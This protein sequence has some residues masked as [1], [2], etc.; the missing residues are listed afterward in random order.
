M[1]AERWKRVDELLQAALRVPAE[2]QEK[3]LREQ[4]G[5]NAELL[6]E[7]RSLL[8]S[9]RRAGSFLEPPAIDLRGF[10]FIRCQACGTKNAEPAQRCQ[11]C[12]ATLDTSLTMSISSEVASDG[13]GSASR[14]RPS[15]G[16]G[17]APG[18]MVAAR[19][20][21]VSLLGRGGMGEVYGAD[22]LK[23]GQRVALKF[24]PA[25]RLNS[26]SWRDQFY[27]EVRM[28]R[29]VSHPNV[30]RV[31]DV[32]ESDGHLF[33]SMEFV[34]GEDLASLLRRIGRLP[35]DKA[36]EIA[37]QL[38][39]GL[40]AAHRSGVLHRDLK[41]SNVMIDGKGHARITDFGL[42]VATSNAEKE[43]SP[44]GTP[45]YLA[46][47]L[48]DGHPPSVQSDLYALGLVLYELFTGKRAFEAS[49][50]AEFHRKQS[51]TNPTPP[52]NVVKNLDPAVERTILRCLDRD[53]EQRPRSALSV[54]AALPGGDPLAAALA[55]GETPSPEMVAAAGPEGSLRPAT[56]WICFLSA[57]VLMIVTL[58]FLSPRLMSWGR[59]PMNKSPEVLTDRAQE[60]SEKLG[61]SGALDWASWLETEY[62]YLDYVADDPAGKKVVSAAVARPWPAP[63]SFWYRQSPEWMT[64][65]QR[66]EYSDV[67]QSQPPYE[68]VGMV[69]LNL[70]V[71]GK[72]LFLRAVPPQVGTGNAPEPD[73]GLLFDAAGLDKSQ[74]HPAE[75]KWLPPEA[76]DSR[77]DW[78]GHIAGQPDL[79]LHVAAAAYRGVPVYFQMIAPWD[80]PLRNPSPGLVGVKAKLA[81]SL[82]VLIFS[83][84][85]LVGGFFAIRNIRRGRGDSKGGLRF[86]S[87]TAVL[88]GVGVVSNEHFVPDPGYNIVQ[89][90]FLGM[91]LFVAVVCWIGYMAVEP[92]ARRVW[93]NVLVSWQRLLNG[94]IRDPLMGRHLLLGI[95]VGAAVQAVRGC[96]VVLSHSLRMT[97]V[98]YEFCRGLFSSIGNGLYFL[99][100]YWMTALV[101]LAVLSF[102]TRFVRLRWLATV[103][104]GVLMIVI[105]APNDVVGLWRLGLFYGVG[106]VVLT[107]IGFIGVIG[108]FLTDILTEAPPLDFSKWYAGR[109]IAALVVPLALL[110]YGFYVSL[111]GQPMF[112]RASKED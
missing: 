95:L 50:A 78:E 16:L 51:E 20:R 60:L 70:D 77:A 5:G 23:L 36:V 102:L 66:Q 96:V 99:P 9:D 82:A 110:A 107:R 17:F 14:K 41:P 25:D 24:L 111:G 12:G 54:S 68:I 7:V 11:R 44:A 93:P 22:D 38:C 10:V 87:V 2:R 57:A 97:P 67:T 75:P 109:A 69:A 106:L 33:L 84:Y 6:E 45:G 28:A 104:T 81:S 27:A 26:N 29:Q 94:G 71:Q 43:R 40:A 73:W 88:F 92:Y 72:L 89:F 83:S 13:R 74:F 8:S 21:V 4:C 79:P 52:S 56:A 15:Q 80:M 55:A 112:G 35:D 34:D 49:S 64:P 108:F 61:Y 90:S 76:F 63:V 46:P 98:G 103:I 37:Q 62:D 101:T 18:S 42:A 30:C 100:V 32:G 91:A 31:Y 39:G 19:Y 85:L 59:T 1:D 48:Y 105:D 3:F 47:E 86:A 58:M 53:P 65:R